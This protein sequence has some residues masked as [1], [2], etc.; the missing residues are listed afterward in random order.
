MRKHRHTPDET[1][2]ATHR[3]PLLNWRNRCGN[4]LAARS[5][6]G[7]SQYMAPEV[8][9]EGEY[10]ARCDWW[11]LGII[12]YEC[13]Y[14]QTPFLSE[15]GGRQETKR[16]IVNH[17]TTFG[18]QCRPAVSRRCM[19]LMAALVR[20]KETRL[21]SSRYQTQNQTPLST[22]FSAPPGRSQNRSRAGRSVF[23]FD[24]E[25]IKAHRWFR[26]VPWDRLHL[27]TPPFVPQISGCDDTH[28]FD[29]DESISEWSESIPEDST[30]TTSAEGAPNITARGVALD[31]PVV[32]PLPTPSAGAL[33]GPYVPSVPS[34]ATV[35][36]GN[37]RRRD[38]LQAQLAAYPE[39]TRDLLI[40]LIARPYDSAR[41]NRIDEAIEE[42]A[43]SPKEETRLK[44]FVRLFGRK[45][46]KRPRDRLLRDRD[47]KGVALEVR[48][49]SAFL[50]YTWRRRQP[51]HLRAAAEDRGGGPGLD[52]TNYSCRRSGTW[53]RYGVAQ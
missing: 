8:I 41:L 43:A 6:V 53:G 29:E 20:D 24:A 44:K 9:R 7:T 27:V 21:C 33:G 4:R 34:A 31:E 17:R 1:A 23:P 40:K 15:D 49:Q 22:R 35:A 10:D 16:N 18:F 25:D 51:G 42:A 5:I 26:G 3:E 47:T 2:E 30:D 46:R 38:A 37:S 45:Q 28:Y 14:G 32:G 11:S 48:K 12:L 50:G 13:L 36:H 39:D 19:D 52:G